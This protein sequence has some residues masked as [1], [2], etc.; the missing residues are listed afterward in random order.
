M[1]ATVPIQCPTCGVVYSLRYEPMS[2]EDEAPTLAEN[3]LRDECP[4]HAGKSWTFW[5]K[6]K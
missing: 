3:Q 4:D 2:P 5:G 6:I 1:A